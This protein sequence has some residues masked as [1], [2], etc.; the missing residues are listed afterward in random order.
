MQALAREMNL[1]ETAFVAPIDGGY[2]LRWFTPA[3]EVDLC[4]HATLA[5]AWVLSEQGHGH[6]LRF[7]TR[8]GWL[9][10]RRVEGQ[11][12]DWIEMD[13]PATPARPCEAPGTLT[14]GLGVEAIE[15][16]ECPAYYLV[17]LPNEA[18]VRAL[19][20]DLGL[21]S[22]LAGKG[23]CV[24]APVDGGPWDF[25]SR[26]FAPAKGVDEDPVTGSTHCMLG[27][28]WGERLG[29]D[30]LVGYQA[31]SRG[32]EVRVRLADSRVQLRGQAVTVSRVL[33]RA[34]AQ[35]NASAAQ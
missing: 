19:K 9:A 27:P 3:V 2:S 21:W 5:T 12:G 23:V 28:Y 33:L 7:H 20:P 18:A 29:L 15:V 32:G 10:C 25:V 11:P 34:A 16:L 31:S 17:R 22:Q 24:T 13:F 35:P 30:D 1:S 6:E 4:G 26:L 8:S 14:Q